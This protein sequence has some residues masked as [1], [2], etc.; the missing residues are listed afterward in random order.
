LVQEFINIQEN[1]SICSKMIRI[2]SY[3]ENILR[4]T[5]KQFKEYFKE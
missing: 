2:E 5:T 3:M 1:I 4:L